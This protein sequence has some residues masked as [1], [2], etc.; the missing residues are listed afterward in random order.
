V[1]FSKFPAAPS[2]NIAKNR[3]GIDKY[4]LTLVVLSGSVSSKALSILLDPGE[5]PAIGFESDISSL[6]EKDEENDDCPER[7]K[8]QEESFSIV[9]AVVTLNK[10]RG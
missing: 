2:S 1:L 6:R 4:F 5:R 8:Q 9:V 10:R 7:R 3:T